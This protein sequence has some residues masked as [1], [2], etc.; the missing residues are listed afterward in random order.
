MKNRVAL[1]VLS[2]VIGL[3]VG[4]AVP[5]M[6][7][8]GKYSESLYAYKKTPND[9]TRM[10]HKKSLEDILLKSETYK[11]K[12]PPGVYFEYG[13]FFAKEGNS[14]EALKY[15]DLEKLT[16]PESGYFVDKMKAQMTVKTD[17]T[18]AKKE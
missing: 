17:T 2:I 8:W 15:F 14:A 9:E 7:Y 12:V 13:Y 18:S 6:Y 5:S 11:L 4:C 3:L 10:E 16:Y 1:S